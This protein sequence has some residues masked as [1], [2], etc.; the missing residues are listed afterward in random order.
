MTVKVLHGRFKSSAGDAPF[1]DY[2]KAAKVV[3]SACFNLRFLGL[4]ISAK[5]HGKSKRQEHFFWQGK[6]WTI[7][8]M[9]N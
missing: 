8:A 2:K 6:G 9:T 5:S 3:S 1:A 7:R 4:C